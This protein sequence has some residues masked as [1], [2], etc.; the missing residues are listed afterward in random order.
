MSA[1]GHR[2]RLISLPWWASPVGINL[3]FLL[4]MYLLVVSA[5]QS[6]FE[7]I[8]IRAAHFL[9]PPYCALVQPAAHYRTGGLARGPN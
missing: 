9:M 8:T 2:N 7:G 4:P 6:N 3:G 1:S 5:D